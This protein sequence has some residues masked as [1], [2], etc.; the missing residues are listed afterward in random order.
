[1]ASCNGSSCLCMCQSCFCH[2]MPVFVVFAIVNG[3]VEGWSIIRPYGVRV[4]IEACSGL[5][6]RKVPPTPYQILTPIQIPLYPSP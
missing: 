3:L 2:P 1:M 4:A 6:P 5:V